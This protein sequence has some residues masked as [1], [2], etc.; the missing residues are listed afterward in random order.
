MLL[1]MKGSKENTRMWSP[2]LK[3]TLTTKAG[4]TESKFI[5]VMRLITQAIQMFQRNN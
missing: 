1:S 3:R 2:P 4:V 5:V